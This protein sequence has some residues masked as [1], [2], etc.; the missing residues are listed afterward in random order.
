MGEFSGQRSHRGAEAR[1]PPLRT[2]TDWLDVPERV[3][4]KLVTMV[5]NCLHGK[6]PAIAALS[7]VASRRHLRS[8]SR[9]QLLVPRHNLSTYTVVG[10]FLSWVPLPGTA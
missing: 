10:L 9:R 5:Y 2:A 7:D 3:E 1:W 6:A 4:Y 8:D